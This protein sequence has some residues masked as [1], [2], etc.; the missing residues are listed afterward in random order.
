MLINCINKIDYLFRCRNKVV[1][2]G[3]AVYRD[4]RGKLREATNKNLEDWWIAALKL[5]NWLKQFERS[6]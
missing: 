4:A 1:H 6:D 2:R 5:I 3:N